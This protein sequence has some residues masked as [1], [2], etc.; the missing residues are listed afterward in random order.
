[1]AD[2]FDCHL[3]DLF[4]HPLMVETLLWLVGPIDLVIRLDFSSL[5]RANT[6]FFTDDMPKRTR[7]SDSVWCVKEYGGDY[8]IFILLEFQS[9]VDPDMAGRILEY[10]SLLHR[11]LIKHKILAGSD[12]RPV[13]FPIVINLT[14]E[15]QESAKD[16][17]NMVHPVPPELTDYVPKMAHLAFDLAAKPRELWDR[18]NLASSALRLIIIHPKKIKAE[19]DCLAG[20]WALILN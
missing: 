14:G 17:Q 18:D 8:Y 19:V 13:V 10:V 7:L 15:T 11:D 6:I 5:Q 1:M 4:G 2:T 12:P 9:K 20:L 16:F 3:R